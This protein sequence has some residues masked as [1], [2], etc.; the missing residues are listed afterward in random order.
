MSKS[1]CR[2]AF[3]TFENVESW[4]TSRSSVSLARLVPAQVANLWR[5]GAALRLEVFGAGNIHVFENI[6]RYNLSYCMRL[7]NPYIY[8]YIYH[9][10]YEDRW[11][12]WTRLLP[13]VHETTTKRPKTGST[14]HLSFCSFYFSLLLLLSI[15]PWQAFAELRDPHKASASKPAAPRSTFPAETWMERVFAVFVC[16]HKHKAHVLWPA[17]F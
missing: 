10:K 6:Y 12:Q 17:L 13:Y 15:H 14:S 1:V 7:L 11:D 8:I 4:N 2:F 3:G 9:V 5:P 16:L